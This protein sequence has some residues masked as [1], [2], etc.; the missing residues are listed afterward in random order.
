MFFLK[1]KAAEKVLFLVVVVAVSG[2]TKP[3]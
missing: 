2:Q 1:N 3:L